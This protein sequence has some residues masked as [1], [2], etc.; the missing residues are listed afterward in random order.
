MPGPARAA[1]NPGRRRGSSTTRPGRADRSRRS[2]RPASPRRRCPRTCTRGETGSRRQR[3]CRDRAGRPRASLLQPGPLQHAGRTARPRRSEVRRRSERPGTRSGPPLR[4]TPPLPGGG[5]AY[6]GRRAGA[7]PG[8]GCRRV[9]GRTASE[10]A[11]E[12]GFRARTQRPRPRLSSL[13]PPRPHDPRARRRVRRRDRRP[14]L[15]WPR[16]RT[17]LRS[18]TAV[19]CRG[20]TS[21]G[22]SALSTA[23]GIAATAERPGA[24]SE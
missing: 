16:G 14:G 15:E 11:D 17:T 19:R 12:Q 18:S 24:L 1:A 13:Q 2:P 20:S 23:T 4:R 3:R 22:S 8:R 6:R 9:C 21:V 10:R 7:P 5:A